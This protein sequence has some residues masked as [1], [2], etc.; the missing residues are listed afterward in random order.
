MRSRCSSNLHDLA[1]KV[2]QE[3]RELLAALFASGGEVVTFED[4]PHA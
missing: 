1:L 4:A 3:G 2:F